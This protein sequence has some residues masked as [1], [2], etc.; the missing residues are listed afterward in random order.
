MKRILRISAPHFCAGITFNK[1]NNKWC[2]VKEET[3]PILRWMAD[4]PTTF[5]ESW[6]KKKGYSYEWL[7]G[8]N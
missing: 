6:L 5:I 7:N 8:D 3:A 2:C 1:E 4:K